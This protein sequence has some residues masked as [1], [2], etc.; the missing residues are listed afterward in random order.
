MRVDVSTNVV[1]V[2]RVSSITSKNLVCSLFHEHTDVRSHLWI[3]IDIWE[4]KHYSVLC[5]WVGITWLVTHVYGEQDYSGQIY[6]SQ[7]YKNVEIDLTRLYSLLYL[8]FY[9]HD[10]ILGQIQRNVFNSHIGAMTVLGIW[11]KNELNPRSRRLLKE[12]RWQVKRKT[13]VFR[14]VL[15]VCTLIKELSAI[16]LRFSIHDSSKDR[17]LR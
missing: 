14:Q 11:F 3:L 7:L 10:F 1:C 17:D 8:Y 5:L 12:I 16:V 2:N 13:V 15:I 6:M 9:Y 4:L